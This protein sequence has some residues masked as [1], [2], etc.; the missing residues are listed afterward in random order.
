[1]RPGPTRRLENTELTLS[2]YWRPVILH[3]VHN[4]YA[5]PSFDNS[6]AYR[7]VQNSATDTI[8]LQDMTD[9]WPVF[10]PKNRAVLGVVDALFDAVV[11]H[12][13]QNYYAQCGNGMKSDRKRL[14]MPRNCST[15]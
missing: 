6:D 3:C 14:Q 10:F 15:D 2:Y 5:E 9:T 11:S 4:Y 13:V 12:G 7:N 8:V 1:M